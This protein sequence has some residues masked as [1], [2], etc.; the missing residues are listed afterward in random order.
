MANVSA[1]EWAIFSR[2]TAYVRS[3][4]DGSV[5]LLGSAARTGNGGILFPLAETDGDGVLRFFGGIRFVGH[6]GM[7][8]V[9]I[10]GL[11]LEFSA[12]SF[13]LTVEGDTIDDR[14]S[15]ASGE[16]KDL[17]AGVATDVQLTEDGS[18]LFFR[19]YPTGQALDQVRL[20]RNFDAC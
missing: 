5:E 9:T 8:D 16:T 20:V 15:L 13:E 10:A 19:R 18:D 12:G 1:L 3:L 2:F 4:P 11:R 7:L 6:G 17:L 14:F